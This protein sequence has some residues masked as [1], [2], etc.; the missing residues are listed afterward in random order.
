[1]YIPQ[2]VYDAFHADFINALAPLVAKGKVQSWTVS[3]FD[4]KVHLLGDPVECDMQS[5]NACICS[6]SAVHMQRAILQ[7]SCM[8]R[9]V[10]TPKLCHN[11]LIIIATMRW[12]DLHTYRSCTETTI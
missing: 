5:C 8:N 7:C 2:S 4:Q 3:T 9:Y 1:M 10:S 6:T 12:S 11:I